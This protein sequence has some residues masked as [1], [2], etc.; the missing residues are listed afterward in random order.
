M[1]I[2][3]RAEIDEKLLENVDRFSADAG[4]SRDR[5]IEMA[6][7]EFLQKKYESAE[8]IVTS[9]GY[10]VGNVRSVETYGR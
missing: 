4:H 9:N 7:E 2:L 8:G 5:I 6:L 10:F 3:I 1:K